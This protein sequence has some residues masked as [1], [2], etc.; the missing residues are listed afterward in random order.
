MVS[1]SVTFR[2]RFATG[3]SDSFL[4]LSMTSFSLRESEL[5]PIACCSLPRFFYNI[6][7]VFIKRYS[8]PIKR[9]SFEEKLCNTLFC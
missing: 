6:K 7:V 3:S 8:C 1:F 5:F 9:H 4:V 2:R